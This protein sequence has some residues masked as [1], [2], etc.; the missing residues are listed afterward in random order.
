MFYT[1][2]LSVC[3]ITALL[4][5]LTPTFTNNKGFYQGH[6]RN[7][8]PPSLMTL[9]FS[10]VTTWIFARSL[11]N[12][13]ILGFYYGLWGVLAYATYYLSFLTGG[14]IV[15]KLRFSLGYADIQSFFNDCYGRYGTIC[16]NFLIVIRLISEIFANLIVIGLIFGVY[17]SQTYFT[18]IA[19]LS[20]IVLFY[21]MKGGLSAALKT[22]LVQMSLF[23]IMLAVL[24][25][26]MLINQHFDAA[27]IFNFSF[28]I[29][30]P[31]P[32]LLFVALLQVWSYPLHDPVMMDRGFLAD[33]KTTQ[34]SFYHAAWISILCIISFGLLGVFAGSNAVADESLNQA[35]SRLLGPETFWVLNAALIISAMSTLD[36]SLASAAKL[37]VINMR[38]CRPSINNGRWVMFIFMLA[39][40]AFI[41]YG[42][43]DLFSAVAVSGTASLFLVP[44]IFFN[45]FAG[46]RDI[47]LW[48]FLASFL[49][50]I[51]GA[52]LYFTESS[53]YSSLLGEVHKY[54]KLLYICLIVIGSSM[55]LFY[56]GGLSRQIIKR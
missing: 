31:G 4:F 14:L 21:S 49:I 44:V 55:T 1:L 42:D 8:A 17:G 38:I 32:I 12:A 47:P 23:L 28:H 6:S 43:R 9:V 24:S 41:V 16:Y 5:I 20:V 30:Q 7:G 25:I 18:A 52:A 27:V 46:R 45:L 22:D 3:L 33:R 36:S 15:D 53:S 37:L 39:A 35:L 2:I 40:L 10:Q 19:L 50:A 13:A 29:S 54:T 56:V 51:I 34:R 48:S 26:S 11:M